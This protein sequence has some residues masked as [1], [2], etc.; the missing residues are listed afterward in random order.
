M[1]FQYKKNVPKSNHRLYGSHENH[2]D[3]VVVSLVIIITYFTVLEFKCEI[4]RRHDFKSTRHV[5]ALFRQTAPRIIHTRIL[6]HG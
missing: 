5:S 6:N 2:G 4:R 1:F 3:F